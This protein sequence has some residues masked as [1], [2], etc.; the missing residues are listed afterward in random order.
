M[1]RTPRPRSHYPR[2][3]CLQLGRGYSYGKRGTSYPKLRSLTRAI[4]A[5]GLPGLRR[6]QH[7]LWCQGRRARAEG[8]QADHSCEQ[9]ANERQSRGRPG[10]WPQSQTSRGQQGLANMFPWVTAGWVPAPL[11]WVCCLGGV[12]SIP[13]SLPSL[14]PQ[15]EPSPFGHQLPHCEWLSRQHARGLGGLWQ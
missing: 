4:R 7:T 5:E 13:S 10:G 12:A 8:G 9:H 2:H 1:P 11:F 3:L 14:P 6:L 15:S